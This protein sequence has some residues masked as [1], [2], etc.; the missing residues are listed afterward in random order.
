MGRSAAVLL[1]LVL[2]VAV[3]S[4]AAQDYWKKVLPNTPVPGAVLD[5]L[6]PGRKGTDGHLKAGLPVSSLH[7]S[8]ATQTEV[9]PRDPN[10]LG[11]FIYG[12][13]TKTEA[14]RDP[15]TLGFFIYETQIPSASSY[16][17]ADTKTEAPRD[18]DTLGFFIYGEDTQTQAHDPSQLG[19]AYVSGRKGTDGH[20]NAGL[21]VSSLHGSPA[22]QTEVLRDPN[23]VIAFLEKDLHRGSK[24]KLDL[25]RTTPAAAFA[26]RAFADAMPFSTKDLPEILARFSLKPNSREE[27]FLRKTLQLCEARPPAGV[28]KHCATSLESMVDFVNSTLGTSVRAVSMVGKRA[29]HKP[30]HYTVVSVGRSLTA[31]GDKSVSC[32]QLTYPYAVFFCHATAAT[33]TAN[34][35][36][37]VGEDGDKV[38]A[39]AVCHHDTSAWNLLLHKQGW[40]GR[41][42]TWW[43]PRDVESSHG[44]RRNPPD[45]QTTENPR[46]SN[47]PTIKLARIQKNPRHIYFQVLKVK[48]GT[49]TIC[50]FM[51]Q[52]Q[53]FWATSGRAF[54]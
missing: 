36:L 3:S 23:T 32:H 37:L 39:V 24:M 42:R 25:G 38:A 7:G 43:A 21:P 12:A 50:H 22:T 51:P 1:F 28:T 53:I 18:P 13:D 46:R 15:D 44:R 29:A 14:T 52:D 6:P 40:V 9:I 30:Q 49:A 8:Q 41:D 10:T 31:L 48:P 19:G 33:T 47:T 17:G 27:A 4:A 26:P 34:I 11:F 2:S 54:A 45:L 35:V 5:L 16:Y 20:L